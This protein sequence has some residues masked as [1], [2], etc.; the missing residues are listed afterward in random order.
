LAM[1]RKSQIFHQKINKENKK[2]FPRSDHITANHR[3][4][5]SMCL[6]ASQSDTDATCN[7]SIFPFPESLRA[8][9]YG[10]GRASRPA[11]TLTES[12]ENRCA[13]RR[14]G[15]E[16]PLRNPA[17][18]SPGRLR[19]GVH[20]FGRASR[21]H[22]AALKMKIWLGL[23]FLLATVAHAEVTEIAL[24]RDHSCAILKSDE[25]KCW[26]WNEFGQLGDGTTTRRTTPVDVSNIATATDIALGQIH[27]CALL[28]D[29]KVKCWGSGSLGDG[30]VVPTEVSGITTAI[31]IALGYH[32]CA[33]LSGGKVMCWG[34]NAVGQLGDGTTTGRLAPVEV[35]GIMTAIN[36]ALGYYH[37]C[38]LLTGGEAMC[39]G[40]N[41]EGELGDGTTT[42]RL[43][44]VE[45][46]SVT[47]AT[48]IAL[49]YYHS[50]ALLTGGKVMCWGA[51]NAGQLGD[52][53]ITDRLTP[54]EVSGITTATSIALG[55]YHS[56][57]LL[58]GGK[59]MCWGNN[60][61]GQLGDGT[62]TDRRNNPVEV[63]GITTAIGIA[64][65]GHHSCALLTG[66]K[67]MCWGNN[68]Y[69]Q[70]GNGNTR[71]SPAPVEVIWPSSPPAAAPPSSSPQYIGAWVAGILFCILAFALVFRR[72]W[73]SKRQTEIDPGTLTYPPRVVLQPVHAQFAPQ[74]Y[75]PHARVV[76]QPVHAQFAP[77]L[78]N[79][80]VQ[81][82]PGGSVEMQQYPP[83]NPPAPY[84]QP[85]LR[86]P[87]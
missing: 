64:L 50:C 11:S 33:L 85:D 73:L 7:R 86:R 24:G 67:M 16:R 14:H 62:I 38:A 60:E 80:H 53:T 32:S 75:N 49:G 27:S 6:D 65:G 77:Q 71:D 12:A 3:A 55:G 39:W 15:L 68:E 8:R 52:G 25:V 22:I 30:T 58:T 74:L 83:N 72:Y 47:M 4:G 31:G 66:G 34:Y 40:L 36:V 87:Q 57:A 5:N 84:P 44:P 37:S 42:D 29:G 82:S 35:S 61:Y 46:S 69:G 13:Q 51:N 10:L 41:D 56:C 45:V 21:G 76:L 81:H 63:S 79:P 78:Y 26:G 23:Y 17:S 9:A 2:I 48:N 20:L 59:V 18:N 1:G 70:L 43:T 54:V 28:K 19:F